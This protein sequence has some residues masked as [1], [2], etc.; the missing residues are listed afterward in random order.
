[1]DAPGETRKENENGRTE[2]RGQGITPVAVRPADSSCPAL[3]PHHNAM[4]NCNGQVS[5]P[6]T[7]PPTSAEISVCAGGLAISSASTVLR[8]GMASI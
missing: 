2:A 7:R 4:P 1:M 6:F 3:L 5:S 8:S